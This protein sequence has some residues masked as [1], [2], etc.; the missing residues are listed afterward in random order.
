MFVQVLH[1]WSF[2]L[3]D[4]MALNV[5]NSKDCQHQG[6]NSNMLDVSTI[7]EILM[8]IFHLVEGKMTWQDWN[9]LKQLLTQMDLCC[10]CLTLLLG[11]VMGIYRVKMRK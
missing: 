4:R 1:S 5:E 7:L 3:L 11:F 9:F 8:H 6:P 2:L 10:H